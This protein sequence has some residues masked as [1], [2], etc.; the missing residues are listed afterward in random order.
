MDGG[1]ENPARIA[2]T[3]ELDRKAALRKTS[4]TVLRTRWFTAL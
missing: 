1:S 3:G 4:D 2:V